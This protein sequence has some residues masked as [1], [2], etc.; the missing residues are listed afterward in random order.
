MQL[1]VDGWCMSRCKALFCPPL[2]GSR[3]K[4]PGELRDLPRLCCYHSWNLEKNPERLWGLHEAYVWFLGDY[5]WH[6]S[7]KNLDL[8]GGFGT[9]CVTLLFFFVFHWSH[10]HFSISQIPSAIKIFGSHRMSHG[11][12]HFISTSLETWP[13]SR[14]IFLKIGY[15]LGPKSSWPHGLSCNLHRIMVSPINNVL[16][17]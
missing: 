10:H 5:Y 8:I 7:L 1:M 11:G 9:V 12:P 17:R 6:E 2:V 16:L 4:L 14:C 13:S 3:R 15:P